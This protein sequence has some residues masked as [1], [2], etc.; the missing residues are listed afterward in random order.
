[1]YLLKKNILK[2]VLC[3]YSDYHWLDPNGDKWVVGG[4]VWNEASTGYTTRSG[5][6]V[7]LM[8]GNRAMKDSAAIGS[9]HGLS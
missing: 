2:Q 6:F 5:I 1:M 7:D 3:T 4:C 8:E 9:M